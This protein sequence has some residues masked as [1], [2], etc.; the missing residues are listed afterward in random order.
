[1]N[2]VFLMDSLGSIKIEKDTTFALMCAANLRNH[3]VFFLPEGN[4]L[5]KNNKICCRVTEVVPQK[6][7]ANPF[8]KK[9]INDLYEDDVH[10]V[11]IRTDP[12]FDEAY[13]M[14]T[15]L[16]DR[17]PQRI[18]VINSPSG[19]RTVNEK[20]WATQF[21]S[22]I[23]KT[24]VTRSKND[25]QEFLDQ[26]KDIII[27]P[28]NMYGGM[29]IF[30]IKKDDLNSS[31]AFEAVS[32]NERKQV[33]LQQYVP[34]AKIG[35]KRILLLDG[36]PLGALLRV[37]R[38]GDHRNNFFTG[39][40][41]QKIDITENDRKIIDILKPHLRSLRLYFV[42][43]DIIGNFLIEVNVTSPTCIQEMNR[44]YNKNLEIQVIEFVE[45]LTKRY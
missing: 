16:L 33:I 15:W 27:K 41:P 6:D 7:S 8:I 11:F 26:E 5:I 17:L 37:H 36:E 34:E 18:A 32:D 4:I 22:I 23:P 38:E 19:I 3:K 30:H 39:G 14:N 20:L 28:V 40:V 31:V 10:A 44:L 25:F 24:V 35:D 45:N 12:P 42:G 13:L 9:E 1:M 2:F 29:S 43:I 21:A